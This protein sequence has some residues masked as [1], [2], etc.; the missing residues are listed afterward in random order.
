MTLGSQSPAVIEGVWEFTLAD[1]VIVVPLLPWESHEG[2]HLSAPNKQ[3]WAN[4]ANIVCMMS[5]IEIKSSLG[6]LI[7]SIDHVGIAVPDL[8]EALTFYQGILGAE[9]MHEE[10]NTEQG[11]NEVM[12]K[13]PQGDT[14]I[15]LLA[16]LGPDTTIGRFIAKQGPGIQQIAFRVS[17]IRAVADHL[18]NAGIRML[19]PEPRIG[20][21]G[22]LVNFAH[23]K[24][25]LGVLCEFVQPA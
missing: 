21:A 18:T 17:D 22:S 7:L 3:Y 5:A 20:T 11:V 2:Q 8:T 4:Y 24:D 6:S 14:Q 16:P 12:L 25:C 15:Q 19:Y 13:F 10:T 23:P 1:A 9:S